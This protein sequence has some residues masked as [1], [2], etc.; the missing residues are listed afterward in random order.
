LSKAVVNLR[1]LGL[2][3]CSSSVVLFEKNVQKLIERGT[4]LDRPSAEFG[5]DKGRV[6]RVI[7]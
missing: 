7:Q 2:E 4:M 1:E 6:V 5:V 3:G